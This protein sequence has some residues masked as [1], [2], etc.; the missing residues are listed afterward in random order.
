MSADVPFLET[1]SPGP[2]LVGLRNPGIRR[3]RMERAY[4]YQ[5]A[6]TKQLDKLKTGGVEV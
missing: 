5:I 3:Q 6:G 2:A 4:G 1:R